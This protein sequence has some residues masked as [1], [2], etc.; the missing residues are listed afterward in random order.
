MVHS[1]SS[2]EFAVKEKV[3]VM[4]AGSRLAV[5]TQRHGSL[6]V[7]HGMI[8]PLRGWSAF[9]F[10][11]THCSW[12]MAWLMA[13]ISISERWLSLNWKTERKSAPRPSSVGSQ[14]A[15]MGSGC[16]PGRSLGLLWE[17]HASQ[18]IMAE[19]LQVP[20]DSPG[21]SQSL[22]ATCSH[23]PSFLSSCSRTQE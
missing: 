22:S 13:W 8:L 2:W 5:K 15:G 21:N 17:G 3:L 1:R 23:V 7:A 4:V 19:T 12:T 20:S 10:S 6:L 9:S 14:G 18:K 11:P 16:L